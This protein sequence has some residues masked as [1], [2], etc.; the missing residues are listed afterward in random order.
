MSTI[1]FEDLPAWAVM[2]LPVVKAV[3]GL[4]R[5]SI[6]NGVKAG[7][8][9]RPV[10]IGP[11]CVGWRVSDVRA[12]LESLTSKKEID[13]NVLKATAEKARRRAE[14]AAELI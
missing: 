8:F 10:Q 6:W 2:R 5:V 9:P 1:S 3:T 12:F 4:S 7:T 11:R 14:K 13:G